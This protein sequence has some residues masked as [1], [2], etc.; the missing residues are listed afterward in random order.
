MT[1]QVPNN[2]NPA[3]AEILPVFSI[4]FLRGQLD[5]D[6]EIIAEDIRNLVAKV[7]ERCP[8][9]NARNYTTYFD[10]DVRLEMY[11]KEWFIKLSEKLKDTYINFIAGAFETDVGYLKRSDIHF[12][13]WASVYQGQH[14]HEI[15]NHVNS[16]MSGTYY[17]KTGDNTAPIKFYSPNYLTN[18]SHG[19]REHPIEREGFHRILFQG[20]QGVD[21]EMN[22]YPIEDEFLLWPSYILHA[23]PPVYET[24]KTDNYER[25]SLSFN[26][27]HRLEID[28]TQ[29]VNDLSYGFMNNE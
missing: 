19:A 13:A 16:Y 11:E 6:T 14:Q 24:D 7:R 28:N 3:R 29:T 22:V 10:E 17:I 18:F 8:T 23:V 1:N 2:F 21:S 12:F 9:D 27:K 5:L 15:H 4:P 26:L 20:T 25:I